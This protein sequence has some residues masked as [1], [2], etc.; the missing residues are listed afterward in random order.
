[1][2]KQQA[3]QQ[4]ADLADYNPPEK[5]GE[6]R[7]LDLDLQPDLLRGIAKLGFQYCS[8]IQALSLIHI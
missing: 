4:G 7:F 6:T 5:E 8:P 1:M 3:V 2:S